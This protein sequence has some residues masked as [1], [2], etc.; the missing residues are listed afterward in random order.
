[1]LTDCVLPKFRKLSTKYEPTTEGCDS[2]LLKLVDVILRD[3]MLM[4]S[5]AI[6]IYQLLNHQSVH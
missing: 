4:L 2:I 5:Y 3:D 6:H 1:M